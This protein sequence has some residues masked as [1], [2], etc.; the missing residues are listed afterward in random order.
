MD[1]SRWDRLEELFTAAEGLAPAPRAAFV[2]ASFAAAPDPALRAELEQMLAAS[3]PA[4]EARLA[5]IVARQVGGLASAASL[6]EP[7]GLSDEPAPRRLGPY[8]IKGEIGR[9]GMATVYEARRDDAEFERTVAVKVLRRGMDTA[10]IVR[11]LRRERQILANLDHP[12]IARLL[13]G[14]RAEDGRPYVVM[15]HIAGEPIDLYC[16]RRELDLRAR[17]Q[18]F[19]RV[20]DAVHYAHRNLVLHRDIKP[21][22]ILVGAEGWPKLLDFGIAKV[23]AGETEEDG[24]ED[25]AT[26]DATLT[27]ARLLTP[28][29]ASPEQVRGGQLSTA[30][31]VY[32]L[33]LL[34]YLLV[35]GRRA[36]EVDPRRPAE[37]ERIVCETLPKPP[38]R[39]DD[40]DLVVMAALRK[41]PERRY[42]SA[43]Q[44]AEDVRRYLENLPVWARKDTAAYRTGKFVRRHRWGVATA[45]GVFC[46]LLFA[47]LVARQQALEAREQK[48]H[49]EQVADFLTEVFETSDPSEARGRALTARE[50]LDQGVAR[51]RYRLRNDPEQRADLLATLGRVYQKLALYDDAGR[52]LEEAVALRGGRQASSPAVAA[53]LRDLAMLDYFRGRWDA[54]RATAERAL[55]LQRRLAAGPLELAETL[56]LLADIDAA[57]GRFAEAEALY[58]ETLELQLEAAGADSEVVAT[59]RNSLGELYF[60]QG[61]IGRAGAAIE[62]SLAVRRRLLGNDH[63]EVAT[64]LNNLAAVRQAR[65]ELDGARRLLAE[66]LAA[67]RR[68]YGEEHVFVAIVLNNLATVESELG[69][70]EAAVGHSEA[71]LAI[72]RKALGGSHHEVAANLHNLGAFSLRL[73]DLGRAEAYCSEALEMRRRTLGEN[74]P[75]VAQTLHILGELALRQ[76]Q[77][78]RA[79]RFFRQSVG[80]DPRRAHTR[81]WLGHSL[82]LLGRGREALENLEA[83]H[84][85]LAEKL[86]PGHRQT[87]EAAGFLAACRARRG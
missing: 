15:E 74:H 44:L 19:R 4:A 37:L 1:R 86:G 60:R 47:A 14:G 24:T 11:R 75:L 50:V 56:L 28:G 77:T 17:L 43:E 46:A 73:R 31:D 3:L 40:L 32:S 7:P 81:A 12:G 87:R 38:G 48:E 83:A 80:I 51:L 18:L 10:D 2:E 58:L 33:G 85:E 54:G 78:R 5:G 42:A 35:A 72:N 39:G 59:T 6:A 57:S 76:E 84:R 27:G 61:A 65:G 69:E 29:W 63:P 67:R 66:V 22:N 79:E 21:S 62:E 45:A 16:R 41:E 26:G 52:L 71:A 70:L 34:L 13:D 68:I 23:L 82:D 55:E 36:Y 53:G 30:S 49:A 9:G 20:C 25:G 8:L 64:S